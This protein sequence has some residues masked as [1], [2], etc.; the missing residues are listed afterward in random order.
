MKT[1]FKSIVTASVFCVVATGALAHKDINRRMA[2][3]EEELAD[4]KAMSKNT[5]LM[6]NGTNFK[7]GGYIDFDLHHTQLSDGAIASGSIARDLYIP[8][9]TPVAS[10]E[11][12]STTDFTAQ[13]SRLSISA[14]RDA[15]GKKILGYVE[16]DFLGS[17]QG[18]Q[19]VTNS[20]SPRLRRAFIDYNNLRIGQ[21]W[22]TFQDTSAIPESASFLALSDGMVFV[23]QPQIRY[24]NGNWQFALENGN[25]SLTAWNPDTES[26]ENVEADSNRFPDLIARYN[27]KG[28]YGKFS[29]AAIVRELRYDAGEESH[30]KTVFGLSIAG[31]LKAGGRDDIRFNIFSGDGLGRYVGLNAANSGAL[32]LLDNSIEE[33]SALGGFIAWRHPFGETARFNV[34]YSILSV[35]Q[36]WFV[37]NGIDPNA[38][39]VVESFYTAVLW[40]IAPKVTVGVEAMYGEREL[41]DG[42]DGDISRLTFS[43]K[44]AF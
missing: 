37:A 5:G 35:D 19:R 6:I 17:L 32:S 4:L 42:R 9:A 11:S 43:T 16:V 8:G 40:D 33:I 29:V 41:E 36:P 18:N 27:F 38:V 7:I 20:Y 15:N 31:R 2:T 25:T 24:T 13:A 3:L 28:D 23:R 26:S 39:E 21:E 30:D 12:T 34:G 14:D 10:G 1:V 44:F 22:S